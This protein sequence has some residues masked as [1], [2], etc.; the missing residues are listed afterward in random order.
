MEKREEEK[1]SP[2]K[3]DKETLSDR[4]MASGILKILRSFG[5]HRWNY[6]WAYYDTTE[7][8]LCFARGTQCT[9]IYILVIYYYF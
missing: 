4:T 3:L 5:S 2:G 9:S 8:R 1:K 6:N 7:H